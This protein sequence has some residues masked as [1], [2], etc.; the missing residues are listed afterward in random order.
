MMG[1]ANRGYFQH[2]HHR[3]YETIQ[4]QRRQG[5]V[6]EIKLELEKMLKVIPGKI[7]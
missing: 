4:H 3:E 5:R 1:G 6:E 7:A 2:K